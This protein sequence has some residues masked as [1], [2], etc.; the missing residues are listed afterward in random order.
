MLLALRSLFEETQ[1]P[2]PPPY[3]APAG[4]VRKRIGFHP[5]FS[6]NAQ[7]ILE[8][9][10]VFPFVGRVEVSG[11][12]NQTLGNVQARFELSLLEL[13]ASANATVQGQNT[14]QFELNPIAVTAETDDDEALTIILDSI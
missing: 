2:V 12:A 4:R 1:T 13:E 3:V 8:P 7:V 10:N 9:I 6:E 14:F 5:V 11:S